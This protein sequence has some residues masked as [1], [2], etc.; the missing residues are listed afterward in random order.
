MNETTNQPIPAPRGSG[1]RAGTGKRPALAALLAAATLV[2]G[3]CGRHEVA[4]GDPGTAVVRARVAEAIRV[5]LPLEVEIYGTVEPERTA[6]VS[7]RVMA[8][9]TSVKVVA[10]DRVDRGQVVI[11]IDPQTAQGQLAQTRGALAQARAALTLAERNYGRFEALQATGA[12]SPLELDTA[13]MNLEQARG[14]VEQ[15][16]GAV[17][18]ASSVASDANVTAPFDGRVVGTMVEVGDLAAPG[19][20]LLLLESA[21]G[22]RLAIQIPESIAAGAGIEVGRR[23]RVAIDSRPDLGAFEAVIT[24]A[25]PGVDPVSHTMSAKIDLPAEGL[26]SGSSGRAWLPTGRRAAVTVPREAILERGGLTLAVLLTAEGRAAARVVT[27]GQTLTAS[28]PKAAA[29]ERVE[30][31]SGL[32]G[33]ETVLLGLSAPPPAGARVEIEP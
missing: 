13:R 9:V 28:G 23:L 32:A 7:T 12:A 16:E 5:D 11:G 29:D 24:E 17:D 8:M 3:A 4:E 19:R 31:L 1:H 20:P 6:A 10:G 2:G 27:V 30:I 21:R 25:A 22:R 33:G 26:A 14:A 15:A 18:A